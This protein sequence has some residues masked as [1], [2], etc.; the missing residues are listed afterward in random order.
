MGPPSSPP[1]A[2][3]AFSLLL[4]PGAFFTQVHED[5]LGPKEST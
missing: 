1:R 4:F 3:G 5:A 2:A